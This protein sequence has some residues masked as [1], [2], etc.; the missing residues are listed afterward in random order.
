MTSLSRW[1]RQGLLPWARLP[2]A[3]IETRGLLA[4]R[5]KGE[6]ADALAALMALLV[7]AHHTDKESGIARL[8]WDDLALCTGVSRAKL[9]AGLSILETRQLVQREPAGRSTFRLMNFGEGH[10]W[11]KVPAKPLY[12]ESGL[13]AFHGFTLRNRAELD[14]MKLYLLFAARRDVRQNITLLSYPMIEEYCGVSHHNIKAAV[15]L[16][17]VQGMVV[18][19]SRPSEINEHGVA[20][21]Y[22]LTFL[23]AR[24]H[25]A[26]T[27]RGF[28]EG[29]REE[30]VS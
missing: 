14:A 18:V 9:A 11:A 30:I 10:V 7:I 22:R 24:Q 19:D 17:I 8:T 25:A 12:S 2:S 27:G 6:G 3:W 26:T 28:D 15:S 1:T 23:Q 21:G 5:W 20:N 29:A 4:F 16:L 13:R